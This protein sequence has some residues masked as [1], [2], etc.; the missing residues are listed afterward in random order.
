MQIVVDQREPHFG[1]RKD[2]V[3]VRRTEHGVDR[4]PDQAGAVDAEQCFDEFDR[5]VADGRDLV[6]G[7]QAALHEMIGEAVG[8]TLDLGER[9]LPRPVGQRYPVRKPCCRAL[10][11]IADRDPSDPAGPRHAAGC[12]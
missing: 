10:E 6:A 11:E 4:H 5:V 7:L 2:I 8:V 12:C 1:M 9:H 3:H